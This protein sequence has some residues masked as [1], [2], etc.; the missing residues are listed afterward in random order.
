MIC[1]TL[2]PIKNYPIPFSSFI[3]SWL[4]K[5][6]KSS[7]WCQNMVGKYIEI[8]KNLYRLRNLITFKNC[9]WITYCNFFKTFMMKCLPSSLFDNL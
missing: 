9:F 6:K 7:Q 1:N 3:G 4:K 8:K 2:N 5:K